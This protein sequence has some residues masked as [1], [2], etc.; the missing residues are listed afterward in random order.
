MCISL[1]PAERHFFSSGRIGFARFSCPGISFSTVIDTT[2]LADS[3]YA[4]LF[5]DA[6]PGQLCRN[7]R[8]PT[9]PMARLNFL[10][11]VLTLTSVVSP[12]SLQP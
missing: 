1:S 11:G 4:Q 8:I 7:Y 5:N 12:L 9:A 10:T 3:D 2:E 6:R